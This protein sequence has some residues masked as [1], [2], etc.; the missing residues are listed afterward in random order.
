MSRSNILKQAEN[1]RSLFVS[2]PAVDQTPH[3]LSTPLVAKKPKLRRSEKEF[4]ARKETELEESRA[5]GYAEGYEQGLAEGKEAGSR[6]AYQVA[7]DAASAARNAE[8]QSFV[9][10]LE[11]TL[12]SANEAMTRWYELAEEEMEQ[13]VLDVAHK[14][15]LSELKLGRE[16]VLAIVKEAMSEI[17]HAS[18]AR[19]RVNPLDTPVMKSFKREIL[20]CAPS[21]RGLEIVDDATIE[22]GCMIETDGG[23]VDARIEKKLTLISRAMKEAA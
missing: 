23:L 19:L 2:G 21:V 4:V 7:Y 1:V 8:L 22:G 13:L 9:A 6:V 3:M 18:E 10:S 11:K 17:T 5:K 20:A 14:V 15:M 16:S 12:A